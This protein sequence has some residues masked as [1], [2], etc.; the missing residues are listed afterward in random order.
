MTAGLGTMDGSPLCGDGLQNLTST[1][2]SAYS[3]DKNSD[4]GDM[5]FNMT[6]YVGDT[7]KVVSLSTHLG[8]NVSFCCCFFFLW[9]P[10]SVFGLLLDDVHDEKPSH[11]NRCCP[12]SW[13]RAIPRT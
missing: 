1:G 2:G 6:N 10:L 4:L 5:Y 9:S 11:A 7:L 3:I 12:P 8:S 13:I